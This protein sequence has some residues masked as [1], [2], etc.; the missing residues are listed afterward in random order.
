MAAQSAANNSTVEKKIGPTAKEQI[1]CP[2]ARVGVAY[3]RKLY[4]EWRQKRGV[5]TPYPAGRKPTS[6]LDAQHL[7]GVWQSRA[8][9]ARLVTKRWVAEHTL[10]DYPYCTTTC[11]AW[12]K[13]TDEVQRVFPNSKGWMMSC[14]ASEGG[15]G[16]WVV[17][18]GR[19]YYPGAE[20]AKGGREVGGNLQFTYGT[21]A[22]MYNA[23]VKHLKE[24]SYRLPTH[25][26][27]GASVTAW[28]SALGQA[29]AGGAA[30]S[31]GLRGNHW[32]GSGC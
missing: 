5:S 28:R 3:Y 13:A 27:G 12:H 17:Y 21:F 14:S 11:R 25:L 29:I 31:L 16:R 32:A 8:A 7:A 6:C 9:Q 10:R 26:R 15:W 1:K 30:Y 18:G 22:Y 4:T 19:S 2:S 24:R 23:G 20:Y